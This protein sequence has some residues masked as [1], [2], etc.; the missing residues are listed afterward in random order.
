MEYYKVIALS[1]SGRGRK[2]HRAGDIVPETGFEKKSVSD[3][4]DRGFIE[5][6]SDKD[7]KEWQGAGN[8]T[9]AQKQ[10][11]TKAA[12]DEAAKAA[13]EELDKIKADYSELSGVEVSEINKTWGKTKLVKEIKALLTAQYKEL[14]GEDA[15]D[16]SSLNNEALRTK[17][18]E[19]ES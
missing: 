18:A 19:L 7:M 17:I 16:V 14:A 3:L 11:E 4:L 9:E 1:C 15:E 12:S 10:A 8:K 5:V 13:K 6:A 2:I